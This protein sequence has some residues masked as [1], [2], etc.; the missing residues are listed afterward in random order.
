MLQTYEAI[1]A[2]S[3]VVFMFTT[4]FYF[5]QTY[6]CNKSPT[7]YCRRNQIDIGLYAKSAKS[8]SKTSNSFRLKVYVESDAKD[9]K[10][11]CKYTLNNVFQFLNLSAE[12][13]CNVLMNNVE[14]C[15]WVFYS[16]MSDQKHITIFVPEKV[17]HQRM[18]NSLLKSCEQ[19][20]FILFREKSQKIHLK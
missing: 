4:L 18:N 6:G 19:N 8:I 9:T 15:L 17:R 5:V 20:T 16:I 11:D 3:T 14:S 10:K 2:C 1:K 7:K 12:I 13:L